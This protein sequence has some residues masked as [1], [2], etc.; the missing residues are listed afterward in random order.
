V[1]NV[2][3]VVNNELRRVRTKAGVTNFNV[4]V[5]YLEELSKSMNISQRDIRRPFRKEAR[6]LIITPQ[7]LAASFLVEVLLKQ[8]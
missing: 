6:G 2:S 1:S 4:T 5:T 7:S 8:S 3:I